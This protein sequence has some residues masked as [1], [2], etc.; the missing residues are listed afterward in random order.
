MSILI[1]SLEFVLV[2][3]MGA[4]LGL[5]V[6]AIFYRPAR[7]G[8][9]AR[10]VHL[11]HAATLLIIC[12]TFWAGAFGFLAD[13]RDQPWEVP[14]GLATGYTCG[15]GWL[16]LRRQR[17]YRRYLRDLAASGVPARGTQGR[18]APGNGTPGRP[19]AAGAS[20]GPAPRVPAWRLAIR[21]ADYA[22][23]AMFCTAALAGGAGISLNLH[24]AV[25]RRF[26]GAAHM[27]GLISTY[28]VLGVVGLAWSQVI[29]AAVLRAMRAALARDWRIARRW[30]Y[31]LLAVPFAWCLPYCIVA[32]GM[33]AGILLNL[34]TLWAG[35][36]YTPDPPSTPLRTL[37]AL[38]AGHRTARPA[39]L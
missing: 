17:R 5:L 34:V 22:M 28:A 16:W 36:R 4:G 37:Q 10:I 9:T 6:V 23:G 30:Q 14:Y 20:S 11:I 35:W 2:T 26:T 27:P 24:V 12:G 31:I 39:R 29:T 32:P 25:A 21:C 38:R 18:A 19:A 33:F 1:A 8:P 7:Y 3:L 15:S 13:M